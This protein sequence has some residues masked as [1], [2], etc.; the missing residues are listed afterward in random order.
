[1]KLFFLFYLVP[2]WIA[3]QVSQAGVAQLFFKDKTL[4]WEKTYQG[5]WDDVIPVKLELGYDGASCK[6]QLFFSDNK[7]RFVVSGTLKDDDLLAAGSVP[8][9]FDAAFRRFRAAV[10]KEKPV[11]ACGHDLGQFR[12]QFR[13]TGVDHTVHLAEQQTRGLFLDFLHHP[14]V[15]MARTGDPDA[16]GEIEVSVAFFVKKINPFAADGL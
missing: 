4:L 11:D 3:G 10:G 15:T 1:M 12:R 6:G 13:R 16:R 14:W 9:Q 2:S 8:R 7:A 5:V